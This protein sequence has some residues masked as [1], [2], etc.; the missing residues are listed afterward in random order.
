MGPDPPGRGL[1]V[2]LTTP[3]RKK[4]TCYETR[5]VASDLTFGGGPLWRRR[6]AYGCNANEEDYEMLINY[7]VVKN[8]NDKVQ[9]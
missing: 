7:I 8:H 1:G 9:H 3:P 4:S 6:P 5:N 2:G